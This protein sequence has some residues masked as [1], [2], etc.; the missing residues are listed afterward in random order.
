MAD[1][2]TSNYGWVKPEVSASNNTWGTKLNATFD[3]IDTIM[4]TKAP[5]A[6]PTFTGTAA[7][8]ATSF[9]GSASFTGTASFSNTVTLSGTTNFT[10]TASFIT[11]SFSGNTSFSG[12]NTF[13]SIDSNG[14]VRITGGWIRL[15]KYGRQW[16][17]YIASNG[18]LVIGD[19]TAGA[20]RLAAQTDGA[21]WVNKLISNGDVSTP[22]TVFASN[23]YLNGNALELNGNGSGNRFSYVDFHA[24]DVYPD[25][26][27]RLIRNP[28]PNNTFVLDHRGSGRIYVNAPDGGSAFVVSIGGSDR[29][30]VWPDG[31]T[32]NY[33]NYYAN[34]FFGNGGGLTNVVTDVR[35]SGYWDSGNLGSYSG[36]VYAPNGYVFTE[37]GIARDAW[38]HIISWVHG[39]AIQKYV[40]GNWYTVLVQ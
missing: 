19:E 36:G 7:F 9:S 25:Y 39:R 32:Q 31:N 29:F 22:S 6:N 34:N 20:V 16:S 8:A 26:S 38:G 1:T 35:L 11:A 5:L 10:G 12:T 30:V 23:S 3:S 33:G 18:N 15:Y 27:T 37:I 4:A 40:N 28:G 21:I 17:S 13:S 24:D 2:V 14:D